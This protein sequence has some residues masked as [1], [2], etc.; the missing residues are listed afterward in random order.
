M[1]LRILSPVHTESVKIAQY[2]EQ[3]EAG[4]AR[5]FFDN[6]ERALEDIETNPLG[7]PRLEGVATER[8]IR[9]VVLEKF[10]YLVLY[11]VL[12]NEAVVFA[13]R[14]ASREPGIGLGH[15]ETT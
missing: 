15:D 4:L 6:L 10:P 2:Y 9:R 8:N 3:Q 14:H 5:R 13:V 1:Q 12:A 7:Y 11:E